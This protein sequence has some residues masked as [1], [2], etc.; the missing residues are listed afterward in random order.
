[1]S[2]V[3]KARCFP[4]SSFLEAGLRSNPSY[5]WRS[6][7]SSQGLV[8]ASA[9][10]RVGNGTSFSI[11]GVLWLPCAFVSF[12]LNEV[13]AEALISSL[14]QVGA[15]CWD[16]DVVRDMFNSKDSEHVLGIP[17]SFSSVD[18]SWCWSFDKSGAYSVKTAYHY[19][20]LG[21]LIQLSN[22]TVI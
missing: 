5:L 7:W 12:D 9:R 6:I 1:M 20:M 8:R 4:N 14:M 13:V 17:L 2:R 10:V 19:L 21:S 16:A 22:N 11:G 15:N 18:D 3:F